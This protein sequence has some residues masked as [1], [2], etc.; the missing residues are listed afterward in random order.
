M[1][2][3][4][5]VVIF[6]CSLSATAQ[7]SQWRGSE[8]TGISNETGL[9]DSWPAG[10]PEKVWTAEGLGAGFASFSISDGRLYTQGQRSGSQHVIALDAASGKKLWE[11]PTGRGFSERRGGGPRGTPTVDGDRI[12][13]LSAAGNLIC[14][15]AAT[16]KKIWES[17][18][19]DRFSASNIR[20]GISESPLIDGDVVVVNPGGRGASVVALNK[21]DG[22]LI[23]KSQ[24]DEAGY[25]SAI[26]TE[27]DGVRQYILLTGDGGIGLLAKNGELLWRYNG[28]ANGTANVATPIFHDNHVFLSSDYGTGCVLLKLTASGAEEVYFNRDMR[29]HYGSS[30]LVNG[31]L[32]GS[33]SRILTAMDFK[34]GAVLWRDRSVGKAQ[35]IYADG[36]LYLYSEDGKLG[37]ARA[38]PDGY[39]ELARHE[40][41]QREF[42]TWA[43]PVV[44]AGKLIIR[45]QD[46]AWAF[47]IRE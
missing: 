42:R 22:K 25:S 30:V 12:Y 10:G 31:V 9:A 29:N 27:V 23:W 19:L 5:V 35:V 20:W 44:S 4:L 28:V 34:T 21:V 11:V 26:V 43:L 45:D 8:R 37:M 17:N 36:K 15:E 3:R 14:L 38:T 39:E 2:F 40:I 7:W 18:L 46:T 33:S 47:D 32:Y 41:G 13:A 24:S 1:A 6:V 16:G